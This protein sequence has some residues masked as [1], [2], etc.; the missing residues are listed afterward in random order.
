MNHNQRFL[1]QRIVSFSPKKCFICLNVFEFDEQ[2][3]QAVRGHFLNKDFNLLGLNDRAR[4][5]RLIVLMNKFVLSVCKC[6]R[7]LAHLDCFNN[8]VDIKQNGNINIAIVCTQCHYEYDFDYPYNSKI[9]CSQLNYHKVAFPAMV[10][11]KKKTRFKPGFNA[12][13]RYIPI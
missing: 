6:K 3:Y 2:E 10:I 5:M 8:Y 9:Y 11:F 1:N 7:K 13:K 12:K 4:T